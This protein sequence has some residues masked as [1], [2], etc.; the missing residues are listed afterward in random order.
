MLACQKS[1]GGK[2]GKQGE[3]GENVPRDKTSNGVGTRGTHPLILG[4]VPVPI[5]RFMMWLIF[6]TF[7]DSKR[8][9]G[10]KRGNGRLSPFLSSQWGTEGNGGGTS[11]VA[12]N[13]R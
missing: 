5:P 12:Q 8:G 3:N 13:R 9:K 7:F 4:G 11:R 2:G 6:L 10:E 1:K